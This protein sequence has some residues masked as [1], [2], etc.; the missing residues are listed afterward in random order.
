MTPETIEARTQ[1]VLD[2]LRADIMR[3]FPNDE[4]AT[5]NPILPSV[6]AEIAKLDERLERTIEDLTP[7][8]M[9]GW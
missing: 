2:M 4:A 6:A 5:F 9:K 7:P 1:R 3:R 8:W